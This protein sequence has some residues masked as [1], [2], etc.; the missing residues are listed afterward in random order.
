MSRSVWTD[1]IAQAMLDLAQ[2]HNP[3][4]ITKILNKHFNTDFTYHAVRSKLRRVKEENTLEVIKT[5]S[6]IAKNYEPDK[7]FTEKE[8]LEIHGYDPDEF[9][10]DHGLSNEW[11][12]TNK[13][14]EAY[15]NF[16][17]KIRVKPRL[18]DIATLA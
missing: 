12:T 11:Q 1:E 2:K 18:L 5:R 6:R 14:G 9:V 13:E 15:Y 4:E 7:L 3:K 8:L 17:S 10:I 16:Q